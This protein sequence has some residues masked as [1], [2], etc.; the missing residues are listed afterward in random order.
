MGKAHFI[1]SLVISAVLAACGSNSSSGASEQDGY[2]GYGL[3][4]ASAFDNATVSDF[5]GSFDLTH[6]NTL[7]GSAGASVLVVYFMPPVTSSEA[8]FRLL[9]SG[10]QRGS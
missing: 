6:T 4:L 2:W 8:H 9:K 3:Y 1:S 10:G 5:N 7:C